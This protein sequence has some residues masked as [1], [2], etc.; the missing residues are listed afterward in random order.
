[1]NIL[2]LPPFVRVLIVQILQGIA[3]AVV[4]L[5]LAIPG[6]LSE[7]KAQAL[8]IVVTVIRVIAGVLTVSLPAFIAYVS[9]RL[10]VP[11]AVDPMQVFPDTVDDVFGAVPNFPDE[12]PVNGT[13]LINEPDF[14]F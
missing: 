13:S 12:G 4:A 9:T 1:M 14:P 3:I 7:L 8:I 5:N 6:S 2:S 10:A 11:T